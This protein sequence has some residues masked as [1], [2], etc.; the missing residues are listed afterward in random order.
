MPSLRR[1]VRLSPLS[2]YR[3]FSL[4]RYRD[5]IFYTHLYFLP[6]SRLRRTTSSF[7]HSRGFS[8]DCSPPRLKPSLVRRACYVAAAAG[9]SPKLC[10]HRVLSPLSICARCTH[11][12][13]C[14]AIC[15]R[16]TIR[17]FSRMRHRHVS[18][19][20]ARMVARLR[21]PSNLPFQDRHPRYQGLHQRSGR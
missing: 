18:L 12:S 11:L 2:Y 5:I 13:P 8:V 7:A 21:I 15:P 20:A 17:S 9:A 19:L 16:N 1:A 6:P 10:S 4:S 14:R 3:S